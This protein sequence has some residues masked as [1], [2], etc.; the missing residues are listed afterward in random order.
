M[1]AS[2]GSTGVARGTSDGGVSGCDSGG[3]PPRG[4]RPGAGSVEPVHRAASPAVA[5]APSGRSSRPRPDVNSR[6]PLTVAAAVDVDHQV[7][8]RSRRTRAQ[9]PPGLARASCAP[10]AG[11][12]SDPRPTGPAAHPFPPPRHG[13]AC[14][15]SGRRPGSPAPGR[16]TTEPDHQRRRMRS[17]LPSDPTVPNERAAC[18]R[19]PRRAAPRC[20]R[21]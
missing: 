9:T 11:D 7:V 16:S 15:A 19:G 17:L 4:A 14:R 20:A 1:G 21:P 8:G 5:I 13:P 2:C 18:Q 6:R 10:P 12:R 3:E